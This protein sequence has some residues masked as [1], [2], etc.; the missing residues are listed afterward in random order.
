MKAT[1]DQKQA[2][3]RLSGYRPDTKEEWVQWATGD[4]SKTSTNDLTFD[5]A[6]KI[7][8]QAGGTPYK[9]RGDNWAYFDKENGQHKYILSLCRQLGWTTHHERFGKV[10]DLTRLSNWLKSNRCPVSKPL[11]K[12]DASQCSR[13]IAALEAMITKGY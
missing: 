12:M 11:K 7:I 5:Q 10:V 1:K 9:G 3:Y 6:N 8:T 4:E 13:I 2:I